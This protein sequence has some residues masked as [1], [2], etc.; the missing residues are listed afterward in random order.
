M[1]SVYALDRLSGWEERD[2][3]DGSF[4]PFIF[5]IRKPLLSSLPKLQLLIIVVEGGC[6]LSGPV[7]PCWNHGPISPAPTPSLY[8]PAKFRQKSGR[9]H[10]HNSIHWRVDRMSW[11]GKNHCGCVGEEVVSGCF[12]LAL[13]S[14]S[15]MLIFV[16]KFEDCG[17]NYILM[18]VASISLAS[19]DWMLL[20]SASSKGPWATHSLFYVKIKIKTY[21]SMFWVVPFSFLAQCL[22]SSAL[23]EPASPQPPFA[24]TAPIQ[25]LGESL[26]ETEN[27]LPFFMTSLLSF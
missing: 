10:L 23:R 2:L 4:S 16:N 7:S 25:A 9:V 18:F 13:R 14:F 5:Q 24:V 21:V 12:L 22:M 17:Y 1:R 19:M 15:T 26:V 3:C 27:L 6:H 20:F 11:L 8:L